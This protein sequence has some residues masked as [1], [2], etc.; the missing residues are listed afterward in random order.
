MDKEREDRKIGNGEHG[1]LRVRVKELHIDW[2]MPASSRL[3]FWIA[4]LAGLASLYLWW[5]DLAAYI[6]NVVSIMPK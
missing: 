6:V 4:L 1:W 2:R 3:I 5:P